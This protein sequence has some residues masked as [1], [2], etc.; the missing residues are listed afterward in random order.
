MEAPMAAKGLNNMQ[1]TEVEEED[2]TAITEI[3][4]PFDPKKIDIETKP[5][6]LDLLLRRLRSTPPE[7]DLYPDFQRK[8]SVWSKTKQSRL[9]ESILIRLPLPAFYF[10][11]SDDNKWLVVDGLQRLSTL[12]NF[13]ITKTLVLE[14]MEFLTHLNGEGFDRLPREFQRRIEETQITAYIIKP[15]TPEDVKFNIFSRIN[16]GGEP[17]TAQE[18]RHALNQGIPAKY[19]ASLADSD[20]FKKATG[21]IKPDRMLNRDFVTRFVAFYLLGYEAYEPDLDAFLNQ[22][23]RQIYELSDRQRENLEEVFSEAM[24][25]AHDIFGQHAFRKPYQQGERKKPISKALF[26]VWSVALAKLSREDRAQLVE[27]R[28]ILAQEFLGLMDADQE[29]IAAISQATGDRKRVHKRFSTVQ[30]LIQKV[31]EKHVEVGTN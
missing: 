22:G 27:K 23:M 14:N 17:L 28:R 30:S 20:S 18:I 3:K 2:T 24:S 11:G 21:N 8:D 26:E 6:T 13:I 5:L 29:F 19:V 7:I 16:T 4:K 31:L 1:Y 10:D 9:I 25:C 15:G 12:R